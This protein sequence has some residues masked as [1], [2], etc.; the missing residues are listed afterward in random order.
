MQR[1]RS[2]LRNKKVQK[3]RGRVFNLI[4]RIHDNNTFTLT[5]LNLQWEDASISLFQRLSKAR[6]KNSEKSRKD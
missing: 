6:L 2:K 1:L 3:F 4:S 5:E